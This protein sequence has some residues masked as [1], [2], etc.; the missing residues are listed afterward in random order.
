MDL[1]IIL[2][3]PDSRGSRPPLCNNPPIFAAR[4]KIQ[5][6]IKR[7][8]KVLMACLFLSLLAVFPVAGLDDYGVNVLRGKD[9]E[10]CSP[11]PS[12][13]GSCQNPT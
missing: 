8:D 7:W 1:S 12:Q 9:L 2:P 11:R 10:A 6:G 5:K 3:R 4:S 13:P